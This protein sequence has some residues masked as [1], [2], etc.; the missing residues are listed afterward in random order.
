MRTR[1]KSPRMR[2]WVNLLLLETKSRLNRKSGIKL[3]VH[4]ESVKK[5]VNAER[6]VSEKF[7]NC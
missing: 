6:F 4:K 7:E 1:R 5:T 2:A 3:G